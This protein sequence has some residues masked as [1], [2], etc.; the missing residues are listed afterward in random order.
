MSSILILCTHKKK[1][2]KKFFY[3]NQFFYTDKIT[4]IL[5]FVY[6][7][8]PNPQNK[9]KKENKEVQTTAL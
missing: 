1:K 2:K 3:C 7:P 5:E 6:I 4:K 9:K 8:R